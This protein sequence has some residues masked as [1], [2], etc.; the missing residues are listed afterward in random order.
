VIHTT[1]N[2]DKFRAQTSKLSFH[3]RVRTGD[4]NKQVPFPARSNFMGYYIVFYKYFR[5]A[6]TGED[7]SNK[8]QLVGVFYHMLAEPASHIS[9]TGYMYTGSHN[10]ILKQNKTVVLNMQITDVL[11]YANHWK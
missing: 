11:L 5:H 9:S 7:R 2:F 4:F 6:D 3:T 10:Y 1:R 8:G